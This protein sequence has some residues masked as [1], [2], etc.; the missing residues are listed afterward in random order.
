[1][2]VEAAAGFGKTTLAADWAQSERRSVGWYSLDRLDGDPAVFLT[3]LA[4]ALGRGGASVGRALDRL[5]APGATTETV[6]AALSRALAALPEPALIVL[7]DVDAL[8]NPEC[9]GALSV[10]LEHVPPG[11]QVV[12]LSR[13]DLGPLLA[14]AQAAGRVLRL[15]TVDLRLSDAEAAALVQAAGLELGADDASLLNA[16]CE[17][18]AT[19]LYLVALAGE[20]AYR[21]LLEETDVGTDRFIGDFLHLEVLD[22]LDADDAHFLLQVSVLDRMSGPLCD[23]MLERSDSA[24][25]L[26]SIARSNLFLSRLD[27]DGEWYRLHALLRD[28]LR[29]E[30]ARHSGGRAKALLGR[31]ADWHEAAGDREAA[32]ECA[33][34]ADD[35]RRA[36][37]LLAA[38]AL[39]AYWSGRIG[40]LE[41]WL[42]AVDDPELLAEKPDVAALGAGFLARLG[43]G[44][45]AQRWAEAA[46]RG[47]PA[48]PMPDG[49]PAE[50]WAAEVRA[51]LCR[52]GFD[53]MRDDA[54]RCVSL[55]ADGSALLAGARLLL[56]FAYLLTGDVELADATLAATIDTALA[57]GASA[58]AT[59]G[60]ALASLR[61]A[62]RGDLR[63]AAEL[64]TRAQELVVDA[65][66]DDYPS[67]ALVHAAGA[68]VAL[69]HGNRSHAREQLEAADR[70]AARTTDA[71]P[72]L[73]VSARL[74]LAH[75]HLGLG[76]VGRTRD[77]LDEID[78]IAAGLPS[79]GVAADELAR[80]RRD[81]ESGRSED[82]GWDS[83]L[84]PAEI[85]LL[86]LLASHL[87]FRE[88]ADRL[89]I[90][91]NTV[92]TQAIAVYRKLDVS[93]RSEAVE[94]AQELGLLRADSTRGA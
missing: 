28:L 64:A 76:D 18:W 46:F 13:T 35:R 19:G 23:A 17:G 54:E 55:L 22:G 4:S 21:R 26:A 57:L 89:G 93:S 9:L 77:L 12:L 56:S 5:D 25:R 44:Q 88:V 59:G 38:V 8:S 58:S 52:D 67:T 24:A 84:T 81:L 90:S 86:P 34:A 15:G 41:R 29:D 85:R 3:Y 80:L 11:S 63:E 82:D 16:R 50:A 79:I 94:R 71:L 60:M 36:A 72:W 65:R 70:L 83:R 51:I 27:D 10:L 30:L 74:E 2:S 40:T 92:K 33:I 87:S 49:S 31:A 39:P 47:D 6:V 32:V 14:D 62:A 45:T 42:D 7:D 61:A 20:P 75:L 69:A 43:R 73:A 66:I 68:R 78:G 48:A 1:V 37:R 53:A 91:R